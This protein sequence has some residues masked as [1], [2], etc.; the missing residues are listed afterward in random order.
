MSVKEVSPR[1]FVLE[2]SDPLAKEIKMTYRWY[3]PKFSPRD[4]PRFA[5]VG[6]ITES[7]SCM[8]Q[9]RDF[10]VNRYRNLPEPPT[11]ILGFD[12]R[13]F[14]FG[15]AIAIELGIPFVLLRKS[16][17]NAGVIIQSEPYDKDYKEDEPEEM[18]IRVG[19]VAKGSRVVLIDDVLATG[20]T[21]VSGLQL[22]HACGARAL[23]V[24]CILA[25][26]FLGCIEKAHTSIDGR[27]K[28]VSIFSFVLYE[29]LD[30]ENCGDC[31]N[32]DGPRV[33]KYGEKI[34]LLN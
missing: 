7:P 8:K 34:P 6:S 13:G 32:Y 4:I 3:T 22:V 31:K 16:K 23:E 20:G 30:D 15:P 19:S 29:A 10:L 17:K 11:H 9:I 28:D 5:D 12:A 25:V 26:P 33:I 2:E 27:F 1:F 21:L 24:C 14:L 18:T